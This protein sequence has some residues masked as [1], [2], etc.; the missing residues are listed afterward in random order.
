MLT[1][2][3]K[4]VVCLRQRVSLSGSGTRYPP[5]LCSPYNPV[6]SEYL[7]WLGSV[8][9]ADVGLNSD[10][11]AASAE[12]TGLLGCSHWQVVGLDIRD[13]PCNVSNSTPLASRV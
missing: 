2:N 12:S 5:L 9:I 8:Q 7:S 3:E 13:D 4:I 1:K 6:R 11:V 10:E